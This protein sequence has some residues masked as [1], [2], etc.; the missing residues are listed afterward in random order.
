MTSHGASLASWRLCEK[1][2]FFIPNGDNPPSRDSGAFP[3]LVPNSTNPHLQTAWPC[4]SHSSPTSFLSLEADRLHSWIPSQIS[5]WHL[6]WPGLLE[7][8]CSYLHDRARIPRV[9]WRPWMASRYSPTQF[10]HFR[11]AIA[12][13]LQ[14]LKSKGGTH[15]PPLSRWSPMHCRHCSD[16]YRDTPAIP[17]SAKQAWPARQGGRILSTKRFYTAPPH[18]SFLYP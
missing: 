16:A 9:E 4:N 7:N 6:I 14:L 12:D 8:K 10:A 17:R 3:L 1:T 11:A 2:L 13:H 18:F 5:G 15:N